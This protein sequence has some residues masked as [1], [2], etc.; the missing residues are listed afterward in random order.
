MKPLQDMD[1]IDKDYDVA[2]KFIES[3]VCAIDE[4]KEW[5][6]KMERKICIPMLISMAANSAVHYST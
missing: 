3:E 4:G 5:L 1:D 2:S 6:I